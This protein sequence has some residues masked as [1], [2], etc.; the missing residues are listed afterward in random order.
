MKRIFFSALALLA[1]TTVN[2]QND[3]NSTNIKAS[4]DPLVNG[5]PYSQYKAQV[6]AKQQQDNKAA[7]A[8]NKPEGLTPVTSNMVNS[9]DPKAEVK[10]VD[11]KGLSLEIKTTKPS[12]ENK[13]ATPGPPSTDAT[14]AKR[15]E[16]KPQA[17]TN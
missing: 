17:G 9:S 4:T 5:I 7:N 16:V 15:S 6:Q 1:I 2:A 13:N 11:A 3:R 10:P 14:P 8:N 12:V